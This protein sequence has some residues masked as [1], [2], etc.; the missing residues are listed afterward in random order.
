M[1]DTSYD[2][3][4]VGAGHNA[5]GAAAY[6]QRCG[7]STLIL[8]RNAI[9]G[10]GVISKELTLPGFRHDCHASGVVH[11]Q[12]HPILTADELEL[13][14]KFGLEF[15][16]PEASYMTVFGD[17]DTLTC[18]G[19]LDKACADIAKFSPKDANAYRE[20]VHF[21]GAIMPMINMSMARPPIPFAGFMGMLAQ[22]PAGNELIASM[23][24][25][26]W[27]IVTERF[28]HPKV[29]LH[30]LKWVT[31][32]VLCEP[33]HK[34]TGIAMLYLIGFSHSH[35]AG[36]P[37]GG[38]GALSESMIRMIEHYGGE[39]RLNTEVTR[40]INTN[41]VARS[42]ELASGEVLTARKAIV[43]AIHPH[44]LG[45][46]VEGLDPGLVQRAKH[47]QLSD[48]SGMLINCALREAPVWTCGT[49]PNS[50]LYVNV[51]EDTDLDALRRYT[52]AL[53]LGEL[54]DQ[55]IA[56][57]S[58]HTNFD[59]S[60]APDGQ[61]TLYVF[62]WAPGVLADGGLEA[63]DALKEARAD[64][65][66]AWLATYAPN[67][68]GD[69]ILA[70]HVDSPFDMAKHSPSFQNGDFNGGAMY[71]Y[72]MMG[73]RPTPELAQYRVPGAEGLY[74]TGPAMHPG[75]GVTGGGRP[76]AIRIMEDLGI[77]YSHIIRS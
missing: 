5:L 73:M 48:F 51:V 61:H 6:L 36:V 20:L 65:V 64:K 60:R 37:V 33:E 59:P 16:Y 54:P 8:E 30:L 32:G 58:N 44:L 15:A 69:N 42:V 46:K 63:W 62:T 67:V 34:T 31:E 39:I 4:V 10:G 49:E 66:M 29:R 55:P 26:A 74:L 18:Y 35:P 12:G 23:M 41:G 24:K 57:V 77:D 25:S 56:V 53:R 11:L 7:L 72:Q 70:R 40:I 3:I 21:M 27:D 1:A 71:L 2:V 28:E 68:S 14:G 19:D 13:K 52:D 45:E 47:V 50:C 9:A 76:V 75:G 43:A 22:M 17:G 38:M